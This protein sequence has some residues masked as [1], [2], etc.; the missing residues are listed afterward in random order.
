MEAVIE[1]VT[2]WDRGYDGGCDRGWDRGYDG[3]CDRGCDGGCDGGCDRGSD[4]GCDGGYDRGCDGGCDTDECCDRFC[5]RHCDRSCDKSSNKDWQDCNRNCD[6]AVTETGDRDSGRAS[7]RHCDEDW[8]RDV[9]KS[10]TTLR[11]GT[12]VPG[13]RAH[14]PTVDRAV[15]GD[16]SNTANTQAQPGPGTHGDASRLKLP[17]EDSEREPSFPLNPALMEELHMN[18]GP[19]VWFQWPSSHLQPPTPMAST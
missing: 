7:D 5:D 2:G 1:A 19:G 13:A 12:T 17:R 8:D 4:R 14:T 11:V 9:T 10:G 16:S 3:G 15:G 6:R 18:F